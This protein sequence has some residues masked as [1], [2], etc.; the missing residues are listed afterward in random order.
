MRGA[1]EICVRMLRAM[2][3]NNNNGTR[4]MRAAAYTR[5]R[6]LPAG[7]YEHVSPA[8]ARSAR[9]TAITYAPLFLGRPGPVSN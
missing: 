7:T 4:A 2:D 3:N 1:F 6:S 8:R 9:P 5:Y